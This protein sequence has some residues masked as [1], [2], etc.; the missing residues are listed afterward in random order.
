MLHTFD[1]AW[2]GVPMVVKGT[3]ERNG[4]GD[5]DDMLMFLVRLGLLK[6]HKPLGAEDISLVEN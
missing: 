1:Y 6:R 2:G 5:G 4:S 3:H